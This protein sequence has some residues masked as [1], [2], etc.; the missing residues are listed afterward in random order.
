MKLSYRTSRIE[1]ILRTRPQAWAEIRG[2]EIYPDIVGWV[3]FYEHS[4]GVI[5]IAELQ[6][7]P[8]PQGACAYP[9]FGFHIHEGNSCTGNAEEIFP[10]VGMHYNPRRCPHPYHAGDLPPIF[11]S[12]GYAFSAFLTDRFSI[13]EIIGRTLILHSAPD[14]FSTQPSGNSGKKIAC[15]EI[16]GRIH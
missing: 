11:G 14:D 8:V 4:L 16:Q 7:L 13:G 9:I 5:L 3:R 6:G 2:S 1:N 15:G 10:N 12:G